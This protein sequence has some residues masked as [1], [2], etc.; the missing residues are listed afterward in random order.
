MKGIS[1]GWGDSSP[2]SGS[3]EGRLCQLSVPLEAP[4]RLGGNG[5]L[6]PVAEMTVR[7]QSWTTA[8]RSAMASGKT[9][10]ARCVQSSTPRDQYHR[11]LLNQGET[12][13]SSRW[14]NSGKLNVILKTGENKWSPV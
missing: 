7:L 11:H 9:L 10:D 6:R 14:L 12:V 2:D 4:H 8:R 13:S 3:Q 5:P 1:Q